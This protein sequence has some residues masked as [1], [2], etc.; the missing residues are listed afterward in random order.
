MVIMG[1]SG[2]PVRSFLSML[3]F[4]S[5]NI[6]GVYMFLGVPSFVGRSVLRSAPRAQSPTAVDV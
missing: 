5:A 1:L 2:N 3:I 4:L 6:A